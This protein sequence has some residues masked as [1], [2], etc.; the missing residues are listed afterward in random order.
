MAVRALAAPWSA[1]GTLGEG[2][3]IHQYPAVSVAEGLSALG[4]GGVCIAVGCDSRDTPRPCPK[5]QDQT[6]CLT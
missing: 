3:S 5:R 2:G 1:F 6:D 4:T